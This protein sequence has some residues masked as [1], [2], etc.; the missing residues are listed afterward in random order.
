MSL[1]AFLSFMK[2]LIFTKLSSTS[3]LKII[4]LYPLKNPYGVSQILNYW[5]Q[6]ISVTAGANS[7]LCITNLEAG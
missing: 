1:H 4:R 5:M 6:G 3:F 2:M 7:Y